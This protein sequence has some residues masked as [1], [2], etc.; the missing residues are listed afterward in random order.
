M[1]VDATK[2]TFFS[3]VLL[4]HSKPGT[5]TIALLLTLDYDC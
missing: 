4:Q 1:Y 2:T 3:D 5:D